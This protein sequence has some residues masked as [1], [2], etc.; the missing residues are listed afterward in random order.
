MEEGGEVAIR[1]GDGGWQQWQRVVGKE[2][3]RGTS[4]RDKKAMACQARKKKFC[5]KRRS[6]L[7]TQGDARGQHL[8]KESEERRGECCESGGKPVFRSLKKKAHR[9]RTT[10]P[11]TH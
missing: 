11:L 3:R 10:K 8:E 9:G 2:K 7:S 5:K 1:G 6:Y 4:E